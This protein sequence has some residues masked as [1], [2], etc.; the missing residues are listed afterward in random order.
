LTHEIDAQHE[1]ADAVP[2]AESRARV[3]AYGSMNLRRRKVASPNL[4]DWAFFAG[5]RGS[6][7]QLL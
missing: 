6:R 5:A 7:V 4:P 1:G 2:A 3:A